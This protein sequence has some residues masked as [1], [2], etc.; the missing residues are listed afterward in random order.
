MLGA[1][2]SLGKSLFGACFGGWWMHSGAKPKGHW[3]WE[4]VNPDGSIA[5]REEYDNMT[6][7]AGLD[8]QIGVELVGTTQITAW[9]AGLI[10]STGYSGIAASDTSGSHSGWTES[11]AYTESLRQTW[12]PGSVSWSRIVFGSRLA[13][14]SR[15]WRMIRPI[16]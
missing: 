16:T 5:W 2:R 13:A 8:H 3:V 15:A 14:F 10:Y 6:T 7:N 4:C 9:F 11:T 1:I 12:T